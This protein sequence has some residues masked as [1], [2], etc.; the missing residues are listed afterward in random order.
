MPQSVRTMLAYGISI[1]QGTYIILLMT[2]MEGYSENVVIIAIV[3]GPPI[4]APALHSLPRRPALRSSPPLWLR[5]RA[6]SVR[7]AGRPSLAP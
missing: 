6:R 4:Y 7:R 2:G 3:R 5:G 1:A